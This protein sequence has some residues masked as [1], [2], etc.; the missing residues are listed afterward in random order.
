MLTHSLELVNKFST[1]AYKGFFTLDKPCVVSTTLKSSAGYVETRDLV[2]K[3]IT[4]FLFQRH[5]SRS[6]SLKVVVVVLVAV[7]FYKILKKWQY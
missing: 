3:K 1:V 5:A 2:E 7:T 6:I 4:G